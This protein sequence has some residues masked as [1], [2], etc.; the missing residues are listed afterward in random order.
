MTVVRLDRLDNYRHEHLLNL[1][2][3]WNKDKRDLLNNTW[4]NIPSNE[5]THIY[6]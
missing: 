1:D 4:I 3:Y 2:F 5:E 6:I